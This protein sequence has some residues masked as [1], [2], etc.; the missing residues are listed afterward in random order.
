MR[1]DCSLS[2][3][4]Y[5]SEMAQ[6]EIMATRIQLLYRMRQRL[7]GVSAMMLGCVAKPKPPPPPQ[8]SPKKEASSGTPAAQPEPPKPDPEEEGGGLGRQEAAQRDLRDSPSKA[9]EEAKDTEDLF[10]EIDRARRVK[11]CGE[12]SQPV[13]QVVF[14]VFVPATVKKLGFKTNQYPPRVSIPIVLGIQSRHL[15]QEMAWLRGERRV[16]K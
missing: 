16:H 8:K 7:F 15:G 3:L 5:R 6:Q 4:S 14:F 9:R 2:G 13:S 11:M 10:K 1:Y 12:A